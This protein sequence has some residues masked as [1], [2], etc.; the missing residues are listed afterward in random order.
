[1][2]KLGTFSPSM[3]VKA[4]TNGRGKNNDPGKIALELVYEIAMQR[5]GV[6]PVQIDTPATRH[7]N[8]WEALALKRYEEKTMMQVIDVEKSI[9]HPDY[10]F[11]TGIPD[12]LIGKDGLVEVKCPY[13]PA[14]HIHNI[15]SF[16]QINDHM[17]QMQGYMWITGRQWCDFVSYDPR[18]PAEHKIAIKRVM[19]DNEIIDAIEQRILL[20]ESEVQIILKKISD[21]K[22]N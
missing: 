17:E 3:F 12:G 6:E 21:V 18:Y 8:E 22:E 7:G 2:P 1:M 4:M 5:I 13:N 20:L 9:Q 15:I 19:R 10:D 11:V 14:N 16:K